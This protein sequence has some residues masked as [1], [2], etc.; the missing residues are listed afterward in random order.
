MGKEIA[1]EVLK[2]KH[3]LLNNFNRITWN[4][5]NVSINLFKTRKKVFQD[6]LF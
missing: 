6:K 1:T 5:L 2:C 3:T 4:Y